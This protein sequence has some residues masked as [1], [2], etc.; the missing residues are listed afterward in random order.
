MGIFGTDGVR[1]RA[2]EGL[3]GEGETRNL[4]Y[5]FGLALLEGESKGAAVALARDTRLSGP[6]L[7]D[8]CARGLRGAGVAVVDLGV[9]PT[10][11]LSWWLSESDE[12]AGGIM[13][14]A[15]HNPWQDNGLKLFVADGSKAPDTLQD[16]C[17]QLYQEQAFA[18]FQEAREDALLLNRH[19]EVV[20]LYLDSL[21]PV[22]AGDAPLD[23]RVVV[24]DTAAGAACQI[25]PEALAR[26]GA[27][28]INCAPAPD[29]RNINAGWGAVEPAAMARRVVHEGAWA[30]VA[31]DGDGDRVVLA[32]E[33]GTVH[34]GDALVGFLA[35]AM[36]ELGTLRGGKVVGTVTSNG[37]LE[38][39]LSSIGVL[40]LRTAV[41]D[42][43][44][45]VA[46][47]EHDLNLGGESS[48][49]VLTPDLCPTGD[50]T[51][52]ALYVLAL[53]ATREEPLSRLLGQVPSFPVAHRKVAIDHRPPL[54]SLPELQAAVMQCESLLTPCG[55][56]LLL[57]YSGTESILRV[58]VEGPDATLVKEC[59]DELAEAAMQSL[60][61]RCGDREAK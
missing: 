36:Q 30:G 49:H 20:G 51:R 21:A 41:G 61:G 48:G 4:A 45:T 60:Q 44:I 19:Q 24:A 27:E 2:G 42:R 11:G 12:I 17:E 28:V 16:R 29:G 40:L 32:D 23:G 55:G 35:V 37:G 53:A 26:V 6:M 9:L 22:V 15:S 31:V 47:R 25:L 5:C 10:P 56:R 33:L 34:D 3:L 52:V 58:L 7:R 59:A 14:T 46:M 1:G 13:I 38:A 50:G 54:D 8:A 39:F 18:F 43:N 57:R